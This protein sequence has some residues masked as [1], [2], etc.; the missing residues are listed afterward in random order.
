MG[1]LNSASLIK[2]FCL[3]LMIMTALLA[4]ACDRSFDNT[5]NEAEVSPANVW[6]Q[7]VHPSDFGESFTLSG[8]LTSGR[9]ADLSARV[10]GL[11]EQV[12]V[13]AGDPVEQGQILV[14]L[15]STLLQ[16]G[17]TRA[18][19]ELT[20]ARAVEREADRQL[21]ISKNLGKN[22][23]VADARVKTRQFELELAQAA[24]KSALA[25]LNEQKELLDRHTL[26]A[27]FPGVI[28]EKHTEAGEW[29]QRGDPVLSLV[30]T[31]AIRL[32]LRVPQERFKNINYNADI[33][34]F[35][36]AIGSIPLQAKV[37]ALVPVV[38]P[39]ERT[40]LLRLLVEDA[41]IS[42]FPGM[43]AR[44]KISL[45]PVKGS[46]MISQDAL[47]RQPDGGQSVF[48]IEQANGGLLAHRK[49]I[50]ILYENDGQ[51]AIAGGLKP[52]QKVVVRGNEA[53]EQD[54][55]VTIEELR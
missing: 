15:D 11:I 31:D 5:G 13:D 54:Q 36:D 6:V 40:F 14:K 20:E 55:A 10:D 9:N 43:S 4:T 53:L 48:V 12:L 23:F 38:N 35:I 32:D 30:A 39:D 52:G 42:L 17:L 16:Q 41:P 37:G 7:T 19:A 8:T 1:T 50:E 25:N 28:S 46:L 49:N 47:L 24:T 26:I 18:I 27:P 34:I 21:S 51:V 33:T 3:P 45:P 22:E 2:V 29:L 44:A